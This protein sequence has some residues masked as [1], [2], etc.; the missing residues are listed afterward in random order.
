MSQESQHYSCASFS[1]NVMCFCV[2]L[3]QSCWRPRRTGTRPTRP[4]CWRRVSWTRRATRTVTIT[5]RC[6]RRD[7]VCWRSVLDTDRRRSRTTSPC[8]WQDIWRVSSPRRE[9]LYLQTILIFSGLQQPAS[10]RCYESQSLLNCYSEIISC[11]IVSCFCE[12]HL[13]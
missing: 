1:Y 6:R 9:S 3:I 13:R 11:N 5:T 2:C 8:S 4:F 10:F 7:G 12:V